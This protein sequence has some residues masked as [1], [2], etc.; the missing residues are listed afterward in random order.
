LIRQ[1]EGGLAAGLIGF[2]DLAI[3]RKKMANPIHYLRP[4]KVVQSCM[5]EAYQV[6]ISHGPGSF[7][8]DTLYSGDP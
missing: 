7:K 2:F 4:G 3:F 6:A 5:W 8:G 1:T